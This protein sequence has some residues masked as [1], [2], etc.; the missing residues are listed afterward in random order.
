[1]GGKQ[2]TMGEKQHSSFGFAEF[3]WRWVAATVLVLLTFNPSGYS[4]YH[5]VSEA[6][7]ASGLGPL[8]YFIGVVLIAAWTIFVVATQRSLGNLGIAI[9]L[10][11]VATGIWLLVDLG[12]VNADSS[13]SIAWISLFAVAF[14]LAVG[15]SW[16]H[17]W[18]RLSG[19]LEVDDSKD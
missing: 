19:Q 17:V 12:V 11:L 10:A 4:Y 13:R 7:G 3:S 18:R 2:T 14:I 15:L 16:S 1:M 8:H 9:L 6:L 5:W